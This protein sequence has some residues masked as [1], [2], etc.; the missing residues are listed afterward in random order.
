MRT[1]SVRKINSRKIFH[2]LGVLFIG[3]IG[4]L[5]SNPALTCASFLLLAIFVKIFWRPGEPPVL[6]YVLC[7]QW[8][9]GSILIFYAD[10]QNLHLTEVDTSKSVVEATWLT[11]IG[12]AV[13]A[14]GIRLAAGK[15]YGPVS[16]QSVNAIASQ[17]SIRRLFLACIIAIAFS[18]VLGVAAIKLRGVSQPILLLSWIHWV[19]VYIFVYTVL[20]KKRGYGALAIILG[21]ELVIGFLGYFSA[22]KVI[23]IVFLM[24]ALAAPFALKGIRFRT[25]FA[26]MVFMLVLGV[27]W[28]GIKNDYREFLNQG[29]DQQVILVP[30]GER[31]DKL[32]ELIGQLDQ[33]KL[34][35]SAE[36]LVR[37]LTYVHFFG[38]A[39]SMVPRRIPYQDGKLWG[40]AIE[41]FLEPRILNPDKPAIDDSR[42]TSYYTG[43]YVAG[44]ED[45]TS[46]SLGYM[47]ESYID[48]GP[49]L[50]AMPIFLWGIFLGW[51]HR[52]LTR[53][54]GFPLFGYACSAVLLSIGAS[55]LEQ[56]NM[57][58][59]GGM[60]LGSV[61]FYAVQKF[62]AERII[63]MIALRK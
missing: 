18:A 10:L 61:I 8:L 47:A 44:A 55:F 15:N 12:L 57:K 50:M 22:F 7:Y 4:L 42:R 29:T 41:N 3:C 20:F 52:K 53:A 13:L 63:R 43:R 51:I 24:A 9:Q 21:I 23:M 34:A 27:V 54:A 30:I 49:F 26:L 2:G 1:M 32:A 56:S 31:V 45:G 58:M 40:E 16:M 36:T 37:R 11:L 25:A 38:E 5:S 60:V 46:I 35:E 33:E 19:V 48:F 17:L 62:S 14:A 28:T 59:V 39:L 6:L